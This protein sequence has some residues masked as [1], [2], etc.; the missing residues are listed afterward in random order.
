MNYKGLILA[1]ALFVS[2]AAIADGQSSQYLLID[3][4]NLI[5]VRSG[6]I[7]AGASVLIKADQ[8]E[9]VA[10][11]G[12]ILVPDGVPRV[13]GRARYLIPGLIDT[14]VH[15]AWHTDDLSRISAD[16]ALKYLYLSRGV[17]GIRDASIQG[18]EVRSLQAR[19]D[20]RSGARLLPRIHVSGRVDASNIA[21]QGVADVADLAAKLNTLGVDS[22]KIRNGITLSDLDVVV[23]AAKR[24]G[25]AVWGHTY[26]GYDD[27]SD[28]ALRAGV[29]GITHILGINPTGSITRPDAP[30]SL[31]DWQA[32]WVYGATNWLYEDKDKTTALIQ[33]MLAKKAWLEPTL[34][35]EYFATHL[36]ELEGHPGNAYLRTDYESIRL[37]FPELAEK[38]LADYRTAFV[39]MKDFVRRYYAAGGW[40][41]AGS[42]CL[43]W[44]GEGL[45]LE[46]ELLVD[47]GIPPIGALQAATINAANALGWNN[48][49][50]IEP[51]MQADLVLLDANPLDDIKNT[52]SIH[53]VVTRGRWLGRAQLDG[54]L[55][56]VAATD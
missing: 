54:M 11:A 24:S 28:A 26:W 13:D 51:G 47:A 7:A 40:L 23:D 31:E 19:E 22:F 41:I 43:P 27:Y 35:T 55:S 20:A 3:N 50:A 25:K 33:L 46:L 34:V 21:I 48:V 2:V 14:H 8:I 36:Q 56:K 17:T 18:Q 12:T 16:E 10:K 30:P 37:G 52:S 38:D 39:N 1:A 53:A 4:V 44:E 45:H 32:A 9:V 5:D 42:D 29:I 15:P 49:G 6:E